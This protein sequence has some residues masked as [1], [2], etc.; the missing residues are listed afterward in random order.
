MLLI[1]KFHI[2]FL[3]QQPH[4]QNVSSPPRWPGYETSSCHKS[5]C[6]PWLWPRTFKCTSDIPTPFPCVAPWPPVL[7]LLH[8]A[9]LSLLASHALLSQP[10]CSL[11][12]MIPSHPW[13]LCFSKTRE[14]KNLC[15]FALLWPL[16]WPNLT[17]YLNRI[18]N[19]HDETNLSHHCIKVQPSSCT[20]L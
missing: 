5:S 10:P 6:L 11:P 12:D 4:K 3:L 13:W 7:S 19:N 2:L 16:L 20:C 8:V 14:C 9:S 1:S 18:K 15:F 17:G